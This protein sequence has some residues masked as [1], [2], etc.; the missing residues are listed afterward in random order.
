[1]ENVETAML[2]MNGRISAALRRQFVTG[3]ELEESRDVDV[4]EDTVDAAEEIARRLHSDLNHSAPQPQ[5]QT[6]T[7]QTSREQYQENSEVF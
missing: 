1:M 3:G 6:T 4:S 7:S 2:R 5:Q